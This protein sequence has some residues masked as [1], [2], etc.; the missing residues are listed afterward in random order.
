MSAGVTRGALQH[1]F[2]DKRGLFLAVL[3]EVEKRTW[4]SLRTCR[5]KLTIPG[6]QASPR[7]LSS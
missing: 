7:W 6:R 5:L 3:E 2:R 4:S 1:H